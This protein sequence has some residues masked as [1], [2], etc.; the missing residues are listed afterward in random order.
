MTLVGWFLQYFIIFLILVL[1]AVAGFFV[2]KK[3]RERKD[4]KAAAAAINEVK[5]EE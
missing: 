5:K 1:I 2:G 4:A 3:L